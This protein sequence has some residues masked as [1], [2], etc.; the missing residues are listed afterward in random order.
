MD[1]M[2]I[3]FPELDADFEN[4]CDINSTYLTNVVPTGKFSFIFDEWV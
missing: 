1:K 3:V 4:G 2:E